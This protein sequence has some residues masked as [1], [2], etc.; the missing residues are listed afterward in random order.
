MKHVIRSWTLPL[1]GIALLVAVMAGVSLGNATVS[2]INP[3]YFEAPRAP[4]LRPLVLDEVPATN[5]AR[6][7]PSYGQLYG[8]E[9]GQAAM[10]AACGSAC[11]DAGV[12]TAS[13][14]YFGSREESDAREARRQRDI[15]SAYAE[16]VLVSTQRAHAASERQDDFERRP[17]PERMPAIVEERGVLEATSADDIDATPADKVT[18]IQRDQE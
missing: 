5:L 3:A 15:D 12:Y 4:R 2:G 17:A 14:P 8:W 9:Q 18:P 13:V 10:T 1:L 7:M 11:G 6:R 16:E